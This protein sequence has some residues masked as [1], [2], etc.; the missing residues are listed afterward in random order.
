MEYIYLEG[1]KFLL[2]A[3]AA[4]A[5]AVLAGL[6]FWLHKKD[7][8]TNPKDP[9]DLSVKLLAITLGRVIS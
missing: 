1:S 5:S 3:L 6:A 9:L 4:S 2:G 7:W 8:V